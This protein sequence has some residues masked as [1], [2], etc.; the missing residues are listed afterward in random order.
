MQKTQQLPLFKIKAEN[1]PEI[2]RKFMVQLK[3]AYKSLKEENA[4]TFESFKEIDIIDGEMSRFSNELHHL[5]AVQSIDKS[6]LEAYESMIPELTTFHSEMGQDPELYKTFKGLLD[7]DLSLIERLV[8][9]RSMLSFQHSGIE[10]PEEGQK[11]L[12]EI[13]ERLSILSNDFSNN[14]TDSTDETNIDLI[15][16]SRLEGINEIDRERFATQAEDIEGVAFRIKSNIPDVMAVLS[17]SLEQKLREEIYRNY[18]SIASIGDKDNSEIMIEILELREEESKLLS[19]KNYAEY[20]LSTKMA[21]TPEQVIDFLEDLADKAKSQ[22]KDE[23]AELKDYAYSK[24]YIENTEERLLPWDASI[25]SRLFREEKFSVNEN[26]VRKYFP[27]SKVQEGLF[28]LIDSLFGYQLTPVD[29]E[30]EKYE[31]ALQLFQIKKDG[32]LIAYIYGDFYARSGKRGGAWMSDYTSREDGIVPVAFVTCNFSAPNGDKEGLLSFDDVVTVFHE[33]GHALH[34][35]LTTVKVSDA[36]GISGVPWDAV[37]LPSTFMEFFCSRP[38]VM[39]KISS[40][41]ETGEAMPKSMMDGI[42]ASEQDGAASMIMRQME[43]S[44]ADMIVHTTNRKDIAQVSFE[45]RERNEMTQPI[46]GVKLFNDFSHVFAGGY[47]AGYYSY[48]WADILASDIFETFEENGVVCRETGDRYLKLILS[49]GSSKCILEM[50]R[51]FKGAEPRPE[52][53][54]KYTGIKVK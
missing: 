9:E 52:P 24:G 49:Q 42:I 21:E 34:H 44:L 37:E 4:P 10:L 39:A 19:Y 20:S 46:E 1:V 28:W 43:L 38:Q 23:V 7:T 17:Y 53:F 27:M 48:K 45:F 40:H 35:T 11:R 22:H 18:N 16:D 30:Y 33:F 54:L 51:D 25:V 36:S 8:I 2:Y 15:D 14:V 5:I 50:F 3:Q 32:Q 6:L 41:F 26:E 31:E 13:S 47:A 12:V 29:F